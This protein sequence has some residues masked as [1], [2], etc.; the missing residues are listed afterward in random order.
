M[1]FF[2]LEESRRRRS[3]VLGGVSRSRSFEKEV[4]DPD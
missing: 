1:W 3:E 2:V 4:D